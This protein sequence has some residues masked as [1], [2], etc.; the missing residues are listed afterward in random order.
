M[1]SYQH[2]DE[3]SFSPCICSLHGEH[4][5]LFLLL[6]LFNDLESE[7]ESQKCQSGL[8]LSSSR[9]IPAEQENNSV[10]FRWSDL[11]ALDLIKEKWMWNPIEL[12]IIRNPALYYGET[13]MRFSES[14][15]VSILS[16]MACW[17]DMIGV[18]SQSTAFWGLV[19]KSSQ[20]EPL[21][22]NTECSVVRQ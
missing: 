14:W 12:K 3:L 4:L 9:N 19:I 15:K 5:K 10:P 22:I 20:V 8:S 6:L 21:F 13:R 2:K 17:P 16:W 18:A 1:Y 11:P 7:N